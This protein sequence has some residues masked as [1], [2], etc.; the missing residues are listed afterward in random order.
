VGVSPTVSKGVRAQVYF[1]ILDIR[2]V[3]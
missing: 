1:N 3:W 2:I